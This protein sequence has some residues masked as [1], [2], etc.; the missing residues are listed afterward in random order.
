[1]EHQAPQDHQDHLPFQALLGYQGK[2]AALVLPDVPVLKE[3]PEQLDQWDH[4]E[5]LENPL[6]L[7]HLANLEVWD[8]Q[9]L[10]V[11]SA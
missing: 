11:A 8:H 7:A 9:V 5:L 2:W 1:M 4:Q 10:P 3:R 6:F